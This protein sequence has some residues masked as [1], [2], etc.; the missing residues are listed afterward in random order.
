MDWFGVPSRG[1]AGQGAVRRG[2]V[3]MATVIKLDEKQVTNGGEEAISF[4]YPYQVAV[5]LEGSAALLFHRWNCDA[6]EAKAKAAKG[7]AAKKTD[8]IESYV[9][10]N[11][12]GEICLPGE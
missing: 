6:V 3:I 9:Y 10:R 2:E 11:D 12:A 8:D 1:E 5:T 4:S 7:S